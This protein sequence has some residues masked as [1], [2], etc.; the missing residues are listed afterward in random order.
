MTDFL[1]R[2]LLRSSARGERVRPRRASLF[3]PEEPDVS[4]GAAAPPSIEEPAVVVDGEDHQPSG[5]EPAFPP[6][7]HRPARASGA[8]ARDRGRPDARAAPP[9]RDVVRGRPVTSTE[10]RPGP[11][12]SARRPEPTR[13]P[14][15][16][17]AGSSPAVRH[18][19]E[20]DPTPPSDVKADLP[21]GLPRAQEPVPRRHR[22]ER[23]GAPAVSELPRAIL[24]AA[25]QTFAG[26]SRLPPSAS[27]GPSPAWH[28]SPE[29]GQTTSHHP[30]P[31]R[32]SEVAAGSNARGLAGPSVLPGA[33]SSRSTVMPARTR[34]ERPSGPGSGAIGARGSE[35]ADAQRGTTHLVRPAAS[36]SRGE[37]HGGPPA[38]TRR[39]AEAASEP[40]VQVTIGRVD[41][42][43]TVP[44]PPP[45]RARPAP[46]LSLDEYLRHRSSGRR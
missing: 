18:T 35:D 1:D 44:P 10:A 15:P 46:R 4:L 40:I 13:L 19:S 33:A 12:P 2:L 20:R 34:P 25:T 41:V 16:D 6:P 24:E 5:T 9:A 7:A 22:E 8:A 3:E 26:E 36:E 38:P 42:R 17:P 43:A 11:L 27:D 21:L 39:E 37:P 30:V 31:S 23:L 29:N 32:R 14:R 28:L 45:G